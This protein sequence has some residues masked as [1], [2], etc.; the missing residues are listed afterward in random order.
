MDA[1][2]RRPTIGKTFNLKDDTLGLTDLLM[3][4]KLSINDVLVTDEKTGMKILSRGKSSFVNPV[5][6]FA[7]HRMKAIMDDLREQF[8]LVIVD[9]APVMAVPDSRVLTGL[10]DKTIFVL[11][12]DS[13]PKKVVASALQLLNKNGHSNVAGIVLQKVN[14]KQYGRY[15]YGDSGY[16]YHYGRYNQYYTN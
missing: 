5:D 9:S 10:V 6:L 13:T 1:D 7:S 12:W 16:Y 11:N 4:H 2:L 14:L 3:N 15:G 8:D